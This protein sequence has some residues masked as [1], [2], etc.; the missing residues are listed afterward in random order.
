MP[1]DYLDKVNLN[2]TTY[3]IKDT[4]SGYISGVTVDGTSVVSSGIANLATSTSHPYNA[5]TNKL[6]TMGDIASAGGGTVTGVTAGAGLT[7]GNAGTSGGTISSSGTIRHSNS[8]TA[9]TTQG[10]YPITID[11]EGHVASYGSAV[12]ELFLVTATITTLNDGVPTGGITDKTSA[13]IYAAATAG[14]LVVL[15]IPFGATMLVAPLALTEADGNT[16]YARFVYE[17]QAN[18]TFQYA[19]LQVVGSGFT[20][21]FKPPYIEDEGVSLGTTSPIA[22]NGT[23]GAA[24]AL[25]N[26]GSYILS[27]AS[28]YG[29]TQ[30]PYAAKAPHYVLAGPS[31]GS[32]NAVPSFRALVTGD[33]PTTDTYSSSGTDPVNGKAINAALQ[34]LD[35]SISQTSGKAISAIT[36]TD[37]KI[38]SSSTISVGDANQNAFSKVKVGNTEIEA[39]STTDTL[40]LVAGTGI[41]LTPDATN[42]KVTITST[43]TG[44]IT[45]VQ[46]NGTTVVSG[47]VANIV[48]N[49]TYNASSNKIATMADVDV[50]NITYTLISGT[51]YEMN[52]SS[53]LATQYAS[54]ILGEAY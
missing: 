12:P 39:D 26:T 51:D 54:T 44:S 43:A 35:S 29:D 23:A 8:V 10:V 50:V 6:A 18:P 24:T 22:L 14:K 3:D 37:G 41:T 17:D 33:I 15:K 28:G 38:T 19:T 45:D 46:V 21:A 30:N 42:D 2:G 1:N 53:V 7:T 9:Q 48:T 20:I 31:S 32:S 5:S 16:S 40:E 27:L 4:I 11:S 49:G 47:G 52:I 25:Q 34:T 13:E 36:I